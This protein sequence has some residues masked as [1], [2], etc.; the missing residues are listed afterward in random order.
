MGTNRENIPS[1]GRVMLAN[2]AFLAMV[3]GVA[4]AGVA[5][6]ALFSLINTCTCVGPE[7]VASGILTVMTVARVLAVIWF[8]LR[9][10]C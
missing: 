1:R 7:R 8:G 10:M 5:N 2:P 3:I 6:A 4:A 9:T